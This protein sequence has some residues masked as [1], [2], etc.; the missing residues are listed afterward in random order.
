LLLQALEVGTDG[1]VLHTENVTEITA[2]RVFIHAALSLQTP[3]S[4]RIPFQNP[5]M[6]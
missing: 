6:A 3:D 1:V 5:K 2:L 4:L